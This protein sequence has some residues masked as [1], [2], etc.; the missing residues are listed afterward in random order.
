MVVVADPV[1][2]VVGVATELPGVV[3]SSGLVVG[4]PNGGSVPTAPG[5]AGLVVVVTAIVLVVVVGM[6]VMVV[7]VVVV[8]D[9]VVVGG[10]STV[11]GH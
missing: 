5:F 10:A 6:L 7:L 9:V 4:G 11:K 2:E 1:D 8:V 3:E